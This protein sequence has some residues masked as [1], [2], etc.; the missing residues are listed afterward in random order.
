MM[1]SLHAQFSD[2]D[3]LL[4][5]AVHGRLRDHGSIVIQNSGRIGPLIELLAGAQQF[6]GEYNSISFAGTFASKVRE[7]Y[8][9]GKPF[10]GGF[11]DQAGAFK[12]P[13]ENPVETR[14]QTWQQ[15]LLNEENEAKNRGFRSEK[16]S[17]GKED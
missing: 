11:N 1:H 8:A 2:V 13:A 12:L 5:E 4:R 6:P 16:R 17:V 3:D 14:D 9:T 15:W 10:G 7:A